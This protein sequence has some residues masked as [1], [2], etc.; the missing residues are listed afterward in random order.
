MHPL[1]HLL[2]SPWWNLTLVVIFTLYAVLAYR[3]QRLDWLLI[4]ALLMAANSTLLISRLMR[5]RGS[6]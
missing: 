3:V 1:R 4:D 5:K 6:R 2:A